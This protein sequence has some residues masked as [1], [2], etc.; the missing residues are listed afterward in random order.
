[1]CIA[2]GQRELHRQTVG[3]DHRMHLAGQKCSLNG[4]FITP[5]NRPFISNNYAF[6]RTI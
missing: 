5:G 4:S 1:M 6:D 3:I 2:G